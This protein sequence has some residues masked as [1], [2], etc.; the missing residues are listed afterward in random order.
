LIRACLKREEDCILTV[1]TRSGSVEFAVQGENFFLMT[2]G[3]EETW[4]QFLEAEEAQFLIRASYPIDLSGCDPLDL[5]HPYEFPED[6]VVHPP[7]PPMESASIKEKLILP[8]KR[9]RE[10]NKEADE[11][12]MSSASQEIEGQAPPVPPPPP[13]ADRESP[14][15]PPPL[16]KQTTDPRRITAK[17]DMWDLSSMKPPAPPTPDRAMVPQKPKLSPEDE[18]I[19]GAQTIKLGEKKDLKPAV[20]REEKLETTVMSDR[21]VDEVVIINVDPD[22]RETLW[23]GRK[24]ECDKVLDDESISR[25]HAQVIPENGFYTI[26]DNGSTNGIAIGGRRVKQARVKPGQLFF[27]GKVL[28]TLKTNQS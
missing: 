6:G 3:T 23:V 2:P 18:K 5:E 10:P 21:S 26:K 14:P 15:P 22:S 28:C 9:E 17:S 12:K 11:E 20:P 25:K 24:T 4:T 27:L 13:G 19:L 16:R 8:G 1:L 7:P